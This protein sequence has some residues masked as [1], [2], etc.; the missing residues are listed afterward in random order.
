MIAVL[1]CVLA[2]GCAQ[3]DIK[4]P[5]AKFQAA[6]ATATTTIGSY[7]QEL[8]TYERNLYLLDRLVDPSKEVFL[9]EGGKDTPLL[10][11]PFSQD[12]IDA[13][14]A[15][16]KRIADYA[17]N[18]AELAGNDA[19]ARFQTN[20]S[21]L[22]TS[23]QQVRTDFTTL[24]QAGGAQSD[25]RAK[26]YTGPISQLIGVIGKMALEKRRS[27]ELRA[28]L[29]EGEKP[30]SEIL[31][32]LERDFKTYIA[33]TRV[34]GQRQVLDTWMQY[35][36][37]NR[38][39]MNL[40]QRKGVLD[41]INAA[42]VDIDAFGDPTA[43]IR[44]MGKAHSALVKLASSDPTPSDFGIAVARI[45]DF[46]TQVQE[47][48]NAVIAIRDAKRNT[49]CLSLRQTAWPVPSRACSIWQATI[50]L[51]K[52]NA[53]RSVPSPS[54][55]EAAWLIFYR[56]GSPMILRRSAMPTRRSLH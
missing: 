52:L 56:H 14:L 49:K 18:L 16:F 15:L 39:N 50:G 7:Y 42:A 10:G 32:F 11:K 5:V 47:L 40:E 54:A 29:S 13:R 31:T 35:Y 30:I 45:D 51:A 26:D 48:V 41:H 46:V 23:L 9:K 28:A 53:A 43:V 1:S 34:A 24:T 33:A 55:Y 6:T 22:G 8:N 38:K 21:A 25:A 4:E 3:L 37:K 36:N 20:I 12:A 17:A 19:P 2:A 27:D 44:K